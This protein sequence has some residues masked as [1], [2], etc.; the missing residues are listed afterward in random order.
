M[1]AGP[2]IGLLAGAHFSHHVLM[3]ILVPLL[4]FIR[5]EFDLTYAQTGLVTSA[6]TISYGVSQ[7]PAGW[8]AD[9]VGSRYLLLLGITGV[10][11]TGALVGIAP[12]YAAVIL[13]LVLM[14][15]AGGGYHPSASAVIANLVPPHR[16]GQALGLHI[17]GGSTSYFLA[18][19]IAAGIVSAVGWRGTFLSLSVPV[20]ILGIAVF[21][22]VTRYVHGHQL[23]GLR[24]PSSRDGTSDPSGP[25]PSETR[26]NDHAAP[27]RRPAAHMTVFLVLTGIMGAGVGSVIP[28]IPLHL[29]DGR[30]VDERIAAGVI[31]IIF[32]A[33]FF[34]APLG[35]MLSDRLGRV[36]VMIATGLLTGPAIALIVLAPFPVP[37]AIA[38]LFVGVLMFVRMPSSEAHI[39]S[40]V[41]VRRRS[42]V[43]G[44]YFFA[45]SE[46]GAVLTPLLGA[47]I[48]RW[49]FTAG[50]VGMGAMVAVVAVVCGLA[51]IALARRA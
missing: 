26:D 46:A 36:R 34:A 15:V 45:S 50:I 28:Y 40:E 12:A 51:L 21:V 27:R 37:L 43:L 44:I 25:G 9:R 30:G 38:L 10:A 3:A 42:T 32:A 49:G 18:P 22:L 41:S 19:L 47:A 16:R 17:I 33:G 29:V 48:D 31:S 39:I 11:V 6:F 24:V 4:P 23:S 1:R 5:N 14:G 13:A 2:T 20:A 7:L 35:G 8:L